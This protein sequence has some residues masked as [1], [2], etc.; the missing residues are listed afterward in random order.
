MRRRLVSTLLEIDRP[1]NVEAIP[2][3]IPTL[4]G[5]T[6][7]QGSTGIYSIRYSD[8]VNTF[9]ATNYANSPFYI[10]DV[11]VLRITTIPATV[12]VFRTDY[13]QALR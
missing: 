4:P 2:A 9:F 8:D 13:N 7:S 6:V 5:V 11:Y 3:A 10:S 12:P 1:S